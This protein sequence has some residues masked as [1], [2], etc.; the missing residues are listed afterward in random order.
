MEAVIQTIP[1]TVV[2]L[3]ITAAKEKPMRVVETVQAVK[4]RGLVGDRYFLGTGTYSNMAFWG[5]NVTLIQSEAIRAVNIGHQTDFTGEMLRRNI[6]TANIK[7][8]SLIGCDFR[9]GS[10]ILR[11]TKHFPPCAHLA[12]LLDR[13]EVL[14]YFAYC[15]GIGAEVVSD[16]AISLHDHIM[17]LD[18]PIEGRGVG[19]L[20]VVTLS[21][22]ADHAFCELDDQ[23]QRNG[24]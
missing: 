11:G 23:E 24:P 8:D 20:P 5:A 1:G 16:G 13:R 15:G 12:K 19:D 14:K 7:L 10:A 22:L 6:V 9:I 4:G 17:I 21:E 3:F 18:A 2:G